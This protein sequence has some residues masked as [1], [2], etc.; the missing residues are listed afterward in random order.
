MRS[1]GSE[2]TREAAFC[3]SRTHAA[4]RVYVRRAVSASNVAMLLMRL[5][6]FLRPTRADD[7]KACAMRMPPRLPGVAPKSLISL[8]RLPVWPH[9]RPLRLDRLGL[10]YLPW[11]PLSNIE[12][13]CVAKLP[14]DAIA[15]SLAPAIGRC[16]RVTV[17]ARPSAAKRASSR[18]ARRAA[19]PS[20]SLS[21]APLHLRATLLRPAARQHAVSSSS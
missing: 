12:H 9:R 14:V 3:R 7:P 19:P 13:G 11:S 2:S 18:P 1:N 10:P 6:G 20:T 15:D 21:A 17:A 16:R 4:A 5:P 8:R